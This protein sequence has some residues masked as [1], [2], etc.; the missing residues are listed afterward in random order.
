MVQMLPYTTSSAIRDPRGR[1][2]VATLLN[3]EVIEGFTPN[4]FNPDCERFF[5]VAT[6]DDGETSWAL[7]ERAGAAGVLTEK[8][9]EG[10]YAEEPVSLL[11]APETFISA[12]EKIC[13]HES[14]GDVRFSMGGLDAAV[15][16]Y[17]QA[18]EGGADRERIELKISLSRYNLALN[19][20]KENR[21]HEA[22][23]EFLRVT[24]DPPMLERARARARMIGCM[25][26]D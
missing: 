1:Q 13:R 10:I 26:G 16:E 5:V 11:D 21:Y 3:G 19:H 7:V 17:S 14:A 15:R 6:D 20:L 4:M 22:R 25:I 24:A 18:R 2:I 12:T 23:A 9:R 8:F